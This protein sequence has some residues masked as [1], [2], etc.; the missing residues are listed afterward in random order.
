MMRIEQLFLDT[1][2]AAP[3]GT[4]A[5]REQR[6]A[7]TFTRAFH[8]SPERLMQQWTEPDLRRRWLPIPPPARLTPVAQRFPSSFRATISDGTRTVCVDLLLEED[9][10]MTLLRLDITPC[11]PLTRDMLIDTGHGDRWETALY[12]LADRLIP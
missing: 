5:L 6:D 3:A 7:L 11:A 10:P 12:A 9:G 1:S 8:A 2:G 4:R